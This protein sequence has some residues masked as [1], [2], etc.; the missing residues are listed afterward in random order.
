[1]TWLYYWSLGRCHAPLLS[2]CFLPESSEEEKLT[3]QSLIWLSTLVVD[4]SRFF[5][6]A[7]ILVSREVFN[8]M[9]WRNTTDKWNS[10]VT[11]LY[12][13]LVLFSAVFIYLKEQIMKTVNWFPFCLAGIVQSSNLIHTVWE[14]YDRVIWQGIMCSKVKVLVCL[15]V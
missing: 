5:S 12:L 2:S 9:K 7:N 6:S 8:T 10:K 4:R 11:R 3:Q 1:M 15:L 14:C 13:T